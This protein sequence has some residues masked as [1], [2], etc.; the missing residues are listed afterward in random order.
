MQVVIAAPSQNQLDIFGGPFTLEQFR[1]QAG[2]HRL[3]R[4]VAPP[5]VSSNAVTEVYNLQAAPA[6]APEAVPA[7]AVP[8][9]AACGDAPG[10]ETGSEDQRILSQLDEWGLTGL[11]RPATQPDDLLE[12]CE[13]PARSVYGEY[14]Q[15]HELPPEEAPAPAEAA[16]HRA[17]RQPAEPAPARPAAG[18]LKRFFRPT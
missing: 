11:R 15:R 1:A 4:R 16:A 6:G 3:V 5:F 14:V 13:R 9:A 18:S 7:P 12:A 17:P 2:A 10:P 8:S